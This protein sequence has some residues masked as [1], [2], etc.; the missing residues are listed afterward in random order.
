MQNIYYMQYITSTEEE[1]DFKVDPFLVN[2]DSS[3]YK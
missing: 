2:M 1:L 3:V